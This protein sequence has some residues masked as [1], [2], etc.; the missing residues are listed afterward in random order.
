M[1]N[2]TIQDAFAQAGDGGGDSTQAPTVA[3]MPTT[4]TPPSPQTSAPMPSLAQP[5]RLGSILSAV[6]KTVTTGLASVP[7]HGRPSFINGLTEGARGEQAAQAQQQDVKFKT[8][9]DQIRAAQLHN[10]D[11]EQ[12][13]RNQAQQD[14]HESHMEAMHANDGDW[15]IE[16]DSVPNNGEAVT[17]HLKTQTAANG[18]VSVPPGTHISGDGQSIL[19]PKDTPET[20]AGQLAQFKAVGPALGLNVSVPN[21]ATKLDPKVA[22]VFYNKLQG[23]GPDGE[24]YSAD[25][26]PALIASNQ[27]RL[28]ELKKNNAPQVQQDALNGIITKQQAQLKADNDAAD[29]A[30][31]KKQANAEAL[32]KVKGE[33]QR[34]TQAAKPQKTDTQM[35]VGSDAK[36][37]QIA[38]TSDELK[39]AGASGVTKLDSDTGKKVITARQLISPQG[40]F[41]MIR[42][43]MDALDAKGKMGSS[44][45]ARFN[46]AM[47]EK[48]GADPDFAPLFNHTHLLSTA[49]MQ[50]HVGSRG[51]SDMMEEFKK[52]ADAGKMNAPT[53][54]AALGA[55]YKYVH[56]K[57]MLPKKEGQ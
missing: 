11:L 2:E 44:A 8:F 54:R 47:L 14:A 19:I 32:A 43:D 33:E 17:D 40:L 9:D 51:S 37:N 38:G 45:Q 21:G 31:A 36:G 26:L 5:S 12:Q 7:S 10:Q 18:A 57:A 35:Y 24:P 15:G 52:L 39:T 4:Q 49:L 53:L 48:A 29:T 1:A 27:Q 16:Y 55:E 6:A 13:N 41:S 46:D 22:T 20:A 28:A 56:E 50:A 23:Y 3:Q 30:N 25:K 34:K 42:Q